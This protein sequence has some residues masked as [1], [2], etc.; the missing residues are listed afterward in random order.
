M[1]II[2]T[3]SFVGAD[4]LFYPEQ[5]SGYYTQNG[6][7]E[8]YSKYECKE[9]DRSVHT[10]HFYKTDPTD[11]VV[12]FDGSGN[13][14]SP[15]YSDTMSNN[16]KNYK[17]GTEN[18]SKTFSGLIYIERTVYYGE[19]S[20]KIKKF[21]TDVKKIKPATITNYC[22][23]LQKGSV[24]NLV[25]R[26]IKLINRADYEHTYERHRLTKIDNIDL[27][28][29]PDDDQLETDYNNIMV[30][31]KFKQS[32]SELILDVRLLGTDS[33]YLMIGNTPIEITPKPSPSKG[34]IGAT[35]SIIRIDNGKTIYH[36]EWNNKPINEDELSKYGFY[37]SKKEAVD[38]GK[39]YTNKIKAQHA[40]VIDE[41]KLRTA[42][43]NLET[44]ST[45]TTAIE[46]EIKVN[47]KKLEL[48]ARALNSKIQSTTIG[49]RLKIA[50]HK[51]ANDR[52]DFDNEMKI[53]DHKRG[54][55]N[56]RIKIYSDELSN[57]N[58]LTMGRMGMNHKFNP[59]DL[60][61]ALK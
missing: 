38:Q 4:I 52:F 48:E 11:K 10:K 27:Y 36:S 34:F 3:E 49:D 35:M 18:T 44:A 53:L 1:E 5:G 54:L 51:L 30:G 21:L 12:V 15:I 14:I 42:E 45:K 39:D 26:A 24:S 56:D 60:V 58:K 13:V 28:I 19:I 33:K 23:L 2:D 8:L 6:N 47:E 40:L 32:D 7:S 46:S 29:A 22:N 17:F 55:V 43:A 41:T 50:E 59:L 37:N 9:Y 61:K 16:V 20:E 25:I 31:S 57:T